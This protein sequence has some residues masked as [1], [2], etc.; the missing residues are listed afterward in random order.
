MSARRQKGLT[1]YC[2]KYI[3]RPF[4]LRTDIVYRNNH[5]DGVIVY[6]VNQNN[7]IIDAPGNNKQSTPNVSPQTANII[8]VKQ[9]W[10]MHC[11]FVSPFGGLLR[12]MMMMMMRR[13]RRRRRR[14][15]MRKGG[16][17]G[18]G[19][20]GERWGDDDDRTLDS[21]DIYPKVSP[22]RILRH[23]GSGYAKLHFHFHSTKYPSL[24]GGQG[25]YAMSSLRDTSTQTLLKTLQL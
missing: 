6:T 14:R 10:T 1:G 22:W 24:L 8:R 12:V 19:R 3:D 11:L 15:R 25:Q 21:W 16:G 13:R 18:R 5:Y 20:G 9:M 4:C 23:K 2:F 7:H 17:R